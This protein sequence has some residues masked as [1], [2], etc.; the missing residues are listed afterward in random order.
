MPE[1][2]G[3]GLW[4]ASSALAIYALNFIGSVLVGLGIADGRLAS[5][6]TCAIAVACWLAL[7]RLWR[8]V[9]S[10]SYFAR[11]ACLVSAGLIGLDVV[12][13]VFGIF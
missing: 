7:A 3:A 6:A 10:G 12:A 4:Q 5:A 1:Q 8:D 13:A 2:R 9:A 11:A